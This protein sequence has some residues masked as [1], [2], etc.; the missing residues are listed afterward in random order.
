MPDTVSIPWGATR[1]RPYSE[2]SP[3]QVL[4]PVIDPD[5]QIAVFHDEQGRT[6]EMGKHGT[7]TDQTVPTST[8]GGGGDGQSGGQ[9]Q[10]TDVDSVTSNDQ[11]Q[12]GE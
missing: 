6:V 9:A 10:P 4:T 3:C 7:S 1:M 8:G 11:D 5:T 2:A 12:S